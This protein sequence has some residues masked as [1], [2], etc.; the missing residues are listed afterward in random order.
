MYPLAVV[1]PG[2]EFEDFHDEEPSG[3]LLPPEDRL[4]RHP[5]ELS[6]A[7]AQE[8]SEAIAARRRWLASTPSRA[9]AGTAGIVGALL[10][11]GLVLVGTHLTGWLAPGSPRESRPSNLTADLFTTTTTTSPVALAGMAPV[12]AK[13]RTA[14][15]RV[16]AVGQSHTVVADG[17]FVSTNGYVVTPSAAIAG[18]D[19]VSVVRSDGEEL[20]ATVTGK[21]SA[22]GIAVLKVQGSGV[23]RLKLSDS[24]T[25]TAGGF[26]LISWWA[27]SL[28]RAFAPMTS[29]PSMTSLASGPALLWLCP[30]SLHLAS[31]PEGSLIINAEG[32]VAGMVTSQHDGKTVAT[33][34]WVISH[35]VDQIISNGYVKHGWLGVEGKTARAAA[36]TASKSATGVEVVKVE[37]DSAAAKAGLRP[38]E[39]IEALDGQPVTSMG[40]LQALLYMM[41]PSAPVSIDV[42]D[43][44]GEA[45]VSARLQPAA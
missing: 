35:V 10:A 12:F 31:A 44:A 11:T 37:P 6:R 19:S 22:S 41:A 2:S 18:A 5:S 25:T 9:G 45:H 7:A 4:W 1:E 29:A 34:G 16:R 23:P 40:Q 33:P 3:P 43:G 21:D 8:T 14:L 36:S 13:V 39:V 38:G 26:M 24:R 20:I 27:S 32:R 28:H 15:V 17:A 30:T 42:L